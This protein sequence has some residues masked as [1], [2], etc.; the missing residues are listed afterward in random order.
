M[1]TREHMDD[2]VQC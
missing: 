1:V 2:L